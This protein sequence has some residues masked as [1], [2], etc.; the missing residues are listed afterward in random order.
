M[1]GKRQKNTAHQQFDNRR[2]EPHQSANSPQKHPYYQNQ[3]RGNGETQNQKAPVGSFNSSG[4][5]GR[6]RGS[7]QRD[8]ALSGHNG[9]TAGVREHQQNSANRNGY[10][11][12]SGER[13]VA[14]GGARQANG[15]QERPP[16]QNK[17]R[18]FMRKSL[19]CSI[20]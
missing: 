10:K 20:F 16:F 6:R 1:F 7:Q 4:P 12:S 2:R 5:Q 19:P 18:L 15:A 9:I 13:T 11:Q 3:Q 8:P 14:G 17:A